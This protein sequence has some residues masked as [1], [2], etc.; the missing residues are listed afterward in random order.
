VSDALEKKQDVTDS[1]R[2]QIAMTRGILIAG[3]INRNKPGQTG[4][5]L[6]WEFS[7][8]SDFPQLDL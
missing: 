7:S 8:V 2:S 3:V 5:F 1:K 6:T 4:R